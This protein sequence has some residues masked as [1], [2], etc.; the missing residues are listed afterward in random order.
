MNNPLP[1][2]MAIDPGTLHSAWIKFVRGNI[3]SY[4]FDENWTVKAKVAS[5]DGEMILCEDI[6]PRSGILL[7]DSTIQTIRWT[8]RFEEAARHGAPFEYLK[9]SHVREEITGKR[10]AKDPVVRHALLE[11]YGGK[12]AA[13]GKKAAPGPLYGISGHVWSALAVAVAAMSM[14]TR[15]VRFTHP[16]LI[17]RVVA[18]D[19]VSSIVGSD[20]AQE[21]AE[22]GG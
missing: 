21:C 4:G 10:S 11:L 1:T 6:E 9:T 15:G 20:P 19:V 8:G 18:D 7:G 14:R 12:V 2:I 3:A 22:R 17:T 13:I 16:G 5:Y